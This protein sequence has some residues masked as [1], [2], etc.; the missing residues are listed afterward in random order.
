M[1]VAGRFWL[2]L[3]LRS[4]C[5]AYIKFLVAGWDRL[6]SAARGCLFG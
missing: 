4:S 5:D 6:V 1:V 2:I 3:W